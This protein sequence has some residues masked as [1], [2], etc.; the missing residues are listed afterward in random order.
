[1]QDRV[2]CRHSPPLIEP[3]TERV[4]AG[5]LELFDNKA[6]PRQPIA[7]NGELKHGRNKNRNEEKNAS[8][9]ESVSV[10][11]IRAGRAGHNEPGGAGERDAYVL[12]Y[13]DGV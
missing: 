7:F 4:M 3:T 2:A 13:S 1:M 10:T 8:S 6:S 12:A 9:G 11:R 5:V